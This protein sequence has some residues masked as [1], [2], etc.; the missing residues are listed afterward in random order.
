MN[1]T[2]T[3][4]R[5]GIAL[6]EVL[7]NSSKTVGVGN[8]S[9]PEPRAQWARDTSMLSTAVAAERVDRS[10]G[11]PVVPEGDCLEVSGLGL[12]LPNGRMLLSDVSFGA[13]P[14]SLTRS[15]A[16]RALASR[17]WP[18]WWAGPSPLPWARSVSAAMTCTSSMRLCGTGSGWC[19]KRMWCITNSPSTRPCGLPPNCDCRT[20]APANAE[21]R[22]AG[23]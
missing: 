2:E 8:E 16:L 18:N 1:S 3:S 23:C 14:G 11:R 15:S 4:D 13:G 20:P 22:C 10:A 6:M 21:T 5:G 17:R 12:T 19:P 7:H 9:T